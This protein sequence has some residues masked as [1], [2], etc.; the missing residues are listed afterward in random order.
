MKIAIIR[1]DKMPVDK[2]VPFT[3]THCKEIVAHY[4]DVQI[5]VQTSTVRCYSDQEY[6]D[7]GVAVVEDVSHC[8]VL[9]GVKEVP[10]ENLIANKTYFFFSHTIK[11]QSYNRSLLQTVLAKNIQL[12]DYETLTDQKGIRI[13]AFGRYAGLVG[14]YNGIRA[15]GKRN[16]LFELKPAN[17]CFDLEEMLTNLDKIRL[18]KIN[19]VLTGGGR[20]AGGAMEVLNRLGIRQVS[21]NE[22]LEKENQEAVFVQLNTQDY[23]KT[24]N[25]K[26]FDHDTFFANP[27]DFE[28]N[29]GRF[30][31]KSDVLI[32]AAYWDPK[33]PVLFTKEQMQESDFKIRI[34]A[35]ITCDID[36]SVPSTKRP[37]TIAE[38]FYDYNPATFE[39]EKPFSN[40]KNI[41]VMAVD[42]LPCELPR[43]ASNDFSKDL[44]DKVLP[45][46]I[47]QDTEEVLKRATIAKDGNLTERYAYLS[48]Y[49]AQEV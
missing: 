17:E 36:G 46:L 21:V 32:A 24:K 14:A 8:D 1:E 44:K 49:V 43:N 31:S 4:P 40:S 10:K 23:N 26:A 29:F 48:D 16:A 41:S 37:S 42:N 18:G 33:A 15:Y 12:L 5:F 27:Q 22:F 35:D 7:A 9:F 19:I 20:V 6:R 25:G 11:K 47:G 28:S 3:P 38:P 30:C 13:V 2:R 34:I 45:F 39:L